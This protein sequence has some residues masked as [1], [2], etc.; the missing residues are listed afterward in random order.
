MP[1]ST[2]SPTRIQTSTLSG[3]YPK[4]PLRALARTARAIVLL[5]VAL[6]MIEA[7]KI[8]VEISEGGQLVTMSAVEA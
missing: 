6:A 3:H 4:M 5:Q 2:P 7:I 1:R 8:L